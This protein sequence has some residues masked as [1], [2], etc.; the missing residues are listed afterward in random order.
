MPIRMVE[1]PNDQDPQDNN[2]GGGGGGGGR[3][4]LGA[5][6][7]MLLG[8]VFKYPKLFIPLLLLG[9]VFFYFKGCG[10]G[11][12]PAVDKQSST[13]ATGGVLDPKE[14]GKSD[15]F[16]FLYDDNKSNPMPESYSLLKFAPTRGNQGAQGSCVAWSNA[17]GIRTILYAQQTG[18]NPDE[19]AFSPSYLYNNIKL[20]NDCQGSYIQR[21]VEWMQTRGAVPF[22]DFGYDPNTC[23]QQIPAGLKDKAS[24]FVIKGAQR[25]GENP[26]QGL[27]LKDILQIKHAIVAGSP[28]AIGMM[29]GGSFMQSMMGKNVWHP[30]SDDYD[31]Q[32]FGGHAMSVIG[33]DDN[34]EGGCLQLMNSWGR[35]W[36]NDGVAW[37]PYKDFIRFTKEAYAYAPMGKAG[38][39]IPNEFDVEFGLMNTDTK[40]DIPLQ[41]IGSGIFSTKNTVAPGTKFKVKIKNNIECYTYVLGQD[42]DQTC[43]VLYP[44]TAKHS[45]YCGVTGTRVFP[46]GFN[47]VP[48]QSQKK[49]YIAVLI[50][51]KPL[52]YET[53]KTQITAHKQADFAAACKIALAGQLLG[54]IKYRTTETVSF[55]ADA[56]ADKSVLV[57][58]EVRK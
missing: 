17:Y 15:I 54:N 33:Y 52:N 43:Y 5:L 24:N 55:T 1:D 56:K 50:S 27:Q 46:R 4:G 51:K 57:V 32:G 19:V 10:G 47:M 21:A 8:L 53:I 23:S 18:K 26:E 40:A 20:G 9:G 58:I 16:N 11:A 36:G 49:D 29:V 28:V 14:Y 3:G 45:P 22:K 31:M 42:T 41:S 2:P 6:L 13:F 48:D 7:P 38:E 34:L 12:V 35:E 39:V 44:Y 37:V 30:N 25:L